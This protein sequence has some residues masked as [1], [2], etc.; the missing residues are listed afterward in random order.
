MK[1]QLFYIALLFVVTINAQ[2]SVHFPKEN[3]KTYT[4][5][6]DGGWSKEKLK[7]VKE[8]YKTIASSSLMIVD[9]NGLVV[10]AW[11]EY[12]REFITHSVRKSFMSALIG[13]AVENRQLNINKTLKD[14][15]INA[16]DPLTTIEQQATLE[17]LLQA[18]SGVYRP[19]AAETPHMAQTRPKKEQFKPGEFWYYNNW[20]FNVLGTILLQETGLNTFKFMQEKLAKPLG[21]Q[22]FTVIDG[23]FHYGFNNQYRLHPAYMM[24]MS[25]RDMARFGLLFLNDGNWNGSQLL[26]KS[27]VKRSVYP[28]SKTLTAFSRLNAKYGYLWWLY[29][30]TIAKNYHYE[31]AGAGGHYISIFP[32]AGFLV[33]NRV[34]TYQRG[35]R[36]MHPEKVKLYEL[37]VNAKIGRVK[38][39][40]NIK[41]LKDQPK[42]YKKIHVSKEQLLKYT[43]VF[44]MQNNVDVSIEISDDDFLVIKAPFLLFNQIELKPIEKNKFLIDGFEE[45]ISFT[46]NKE[47]EISEIQIGANDNS[48]KLAGKIKE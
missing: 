8:Y 42:K 28:H 37:I 10:A 32:N 15:N 2:S 20:D 48:Q 3:W 26:S 23:V 34:N 36:V 24:K 1:K 31:A 40:P 4:N 30:D 46:F 35:R 41:T 14:F 18:R 7:L 16:K 17:H 27:W 45:P 22:D 9:K 11:G 21:M 13:I 19:A 12:E 38:K 5:V 29:N 33:V 43:G 47:K 44:T 39:S 25:A 6:A